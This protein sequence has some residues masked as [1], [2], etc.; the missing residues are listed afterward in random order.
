M[1]FLKTNTK[2]LEEKWLQE[3]KKE[4]VINVVKENLDKISLTEDNKYS[5]TEKVVEKNNAN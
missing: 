2:E 3:R 4:A 5:D 1:N